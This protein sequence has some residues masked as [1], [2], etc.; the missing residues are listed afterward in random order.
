MSFEQISRLQHQLINL[1]REYNKIS[2]E[3]KHIINESQKLKLTNILINSELENI[4]T[5][6][7]CCVCMKEQKNVILEPCLHFSICEYCLSKLSDC[8]VCRKKIDF[9][10]KIY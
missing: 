8:P 1:N 4:K 10:Y 5:K 2:Y 6:Y 9:F 3:K 7:E